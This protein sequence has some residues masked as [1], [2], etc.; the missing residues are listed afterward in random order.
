MRRNRLANGARHGGNRRQVKDHV[1]VPNHG[2]YRIIVS[3]V[4]LF[5]RDARPDFVQIFFIAGQEIIDHPD[6]RIL[7]GKQGA[8]QC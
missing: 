4:G 1:G 6:L 7:S 5:Q 2:R 8:H 3:N